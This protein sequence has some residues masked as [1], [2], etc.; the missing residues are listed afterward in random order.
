GQAVLARGG[1]A[2]D[3]AL[4]TAATLSVVY[5]HM[6]GIGGDLFLLFHEAKSG[7]T[8]CL[9]ASGR[10]PALATIDA[11]RRLGL[12]AVPVKGPLAVTV[13][14]AVAGWGEAHARF[15]SLELAE[16]LAPAIRA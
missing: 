15:G 9:N 14:G 13:P 5:P 10:A 12:D 16:L 11:F 6:C 1:N 2:L 3:A 7:E 8:H 4:A